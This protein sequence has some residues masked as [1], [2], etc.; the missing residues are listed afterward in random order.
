MGKNGLQSL[1]LPSEPQPQSLLQS[2][3]LFIINSYVQP[4]NDNLSEA[5]QPRGGD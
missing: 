1:K 2:R 3:T 4:Q 5:D